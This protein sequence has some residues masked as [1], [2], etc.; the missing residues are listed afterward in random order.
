[1]RAR[2]GPARVPVRPLPQYMP[3]QRMS[4]VDRVS[5]IYYVAGDLYHATVLASRSDRLILDVQNEQDLRWVPSTRM[6]RLQRPRSRIGRPVPS[7]P[8]NAQVDGGARLKQACPPMGETS[9]T[10]HCTSLTKMV[11]WLGQVR[12]TPASLCVR[13]QSYSSSIA[14]MVLV[15]TTKEGVVTS[16][17]GF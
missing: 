11:R 14:R 8:A 1:M 5:T 7:P 9:R 2:S 16:V 13:R 17:Q 10:I 12:A 6:A 4:C 3:G 15:Y